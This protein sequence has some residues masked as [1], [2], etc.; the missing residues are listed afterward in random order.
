[1][2]QKNLIVLAVALGCGLIAAIAVAKL[3]ARP[4]ATAEMIQVP[5]AKKDIPIGTKLDEKSLEEFVGYAPYPKNLVPQD[6]VEDF[7]LVKDKTVNRTVKFGS[8]L[9]I[10]DVGQGSGVAIPEGYFQMAV[11]VSQ[12]DSGVFV[13]P[14]SRVD[15]LYSE[16]I[17]G[18]NTSQV[19]LLLQGMLVLGV[20]NKD[21]LDEGTGRVIPQIES[22]SL[23]VQKIHSLMLTA[24]EDRGRLKLVLRNVE[25][26]KA[27][28]DRPDP[29][30]GD[31]D[32]ERLGVETDVVKKAVVPPPPEVVLETIY[33][34]KKEVPTNTVLSND[35]IAEF[36]DKLE[37]KVAP[38]GAVTNLENHKG[39]F[40]VKSLSAG[41]SLYQDALAKEQVVIIPPSDPKVPEE[42]KVVEAP[43]PEEKKTVPVVVIPKKKLKRFEQTLQGAV[44]QRIIWMEV[45]EGQWKS[46]ESEEDADEYEKKLSKGEVPNT[47]PAATENK[48]EDFKPVG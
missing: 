29:H 9:T 47:A 41:Q 8:P 34:A 17:G 40:V 38:E 16:R 1:M 13:Q 14:G 24:A 44:S 22:V 36:F 46:F 30:M 43:K 27:T 7:A 31:L 28:K 23:A 32:P 25:L 6:V 33:L 4:E 39:Q 35:T 18:T 2:K 21:R 15:I 48:V 11:K 26:S 19:H 42:P 3:S 10:A 5:V 37:T 20:N 12:V 45:K